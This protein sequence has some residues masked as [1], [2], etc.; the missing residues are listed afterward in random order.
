[1]VRPAVPERELEGAVAGSEPEQLVAEADP[2]DRDPAE[3]ARDGLDLRLERLRVAGAVREHDAVEPGELVGLR[4]C[5][6]RP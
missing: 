5:A 6:G 3:Q 1:M 2:E 4:R